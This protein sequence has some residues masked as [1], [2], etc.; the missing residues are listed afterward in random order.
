LSSGCER[1]SPRSRRRSPRM[2]VL[3]L[4][5]RSSTRS[6][7]RMPICLVSFEPLGKVDWE[8]SCDRQ[9][10]EASSIAAHF[11]PRARLVLDPG[12]RAPVL[13]HPSVGGWRRARE[14][15]GFCV[16]RLSDGRYVERQHQSAWGSRN[17][18]H[19][20]I[21]HHDF[22]WG[23]RANSTGGNQRRRCVRYTVRDRYS[24]A[25]QR[26]SDGAG[27]WNDLPLP[28]RFERCSGDE[29]RSGRHFYH[30]AVG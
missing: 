22:V 3:Y 8:V 2:S 14:R 30:G 10:D 11:S 18:V 24:T 6:T 28:G 13:G 19:F 26:G 12:W 9:F 7:C 20:R 27:S 17:H 15:N 23:E 25:G 1:G 4:R 16:E 29:L 21:R 5:R